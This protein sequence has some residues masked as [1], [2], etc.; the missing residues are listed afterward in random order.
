[1]PEQVAVIGVDNEELLCRLCDPPLSTV[2]PN[3]RRV[4]YE[5]AQLLDRMMSGARAPRHEVLVP[6][7]GTVARQSTDTLAIDDPEVAAALRYIRE[8][9]PDGIRVEDVLRHVPISRSLLERR[10]RRAVGRSPHAEIRHVQVRRA[11]QL[12]GETDLPLKRIAE[13]AGFAHMEYLSYVFKRA[14]GQTPRDYRRSHAPERA[15]AT[16]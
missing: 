13:L 11:A 16:T 12:L 2:V 4:G 10:F 5:A 7:V 14:T 15:T 6:P 1:V 9:A 3:A 8:R